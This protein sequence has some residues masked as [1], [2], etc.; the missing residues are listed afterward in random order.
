MSLS[1]PFSP[2]SGVNISSAAESTYQS[3]DPQGQWQ[4]NSTDQT[5]DPSIY[6]RQ[7]GL[8]VSGG[9]GAYVHLI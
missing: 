9:Y 4:F 8:Q 1:L 2:G 6:S 7:Q 3:F 5:T